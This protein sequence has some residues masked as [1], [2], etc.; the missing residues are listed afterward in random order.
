MICRIFTFATRGGKTAQDSIISFPW[1][2]L[3]RPSPMAAQASSFLYPLI[4]C[5]LLITILTDS[6]VHLLIFFGRLLPSFIFIDSSKITATYPR[7]L[8]CRHRAKVRVFVSTTLITI[9]FLISGGSSSC[10]PSKTSLC[11]LRIRYN[12]IIPHFWRFCFSILLTTFS[13]STSIFS[14]HSNLSAPLRSVL[15]RA[16]YL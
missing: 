8:Y 13:I 6:P 16:A 9:L 7:I 12:E 10:N 4:V 2:N 15:N 1:L 14:R 5:L 3:Y 11:P